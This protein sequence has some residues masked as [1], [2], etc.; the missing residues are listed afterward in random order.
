MPAIFSENQREKIQNKLLDIG[1]KLIKKNGY[2]RMTVTEVT[3]ACG[4][5][6]GT[7][8]TF[9]K[10]KEEFVYHI[11]IYE[12]TLEK[13]K[14][15]SFLSNKNIMT[16]EGLRKYLFHLCENNKNIF[17]YMTEEEISLLTTTWPEEYLFNINNDKETA[18]W[19]L[20]KIPDKNP[21]CDWRI[22]TNQMKMLAITLSYKNILISDALGET[23]ES[24]IGY[25]IDY[26]FGK[27]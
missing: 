11:M 6:K 10:S 20:D 12:R 18:N 15:L 23:L 14:L 5:A 21:E 4:I 25:I 7:F 2:K 26:V 22:F 9:F 8:Y 24:Y 3:N 17:S 19:L 27:S 13:E 16:K 1:F